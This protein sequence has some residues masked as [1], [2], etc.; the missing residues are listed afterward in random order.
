MATSSLPAV[1]VAL[2]STI[3]TATDADIQVAYGHPGKHLAAES[4]IVGDTD[5]ADQA[6]ASLGARTRTENYSIKVD[7]LI[8]KAYATQQE[9]TERAFD[10]FADIETA[11]RANVT[12]GVAG[13]RIEVQA[14]PRQLQEGVVDD[15]GLGY[16]AVLRTL[17][18]VTARI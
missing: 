7:I 1:K 4:V 17:A 16:G 10:V 11:L 18:R 9:A 8:L 2:V 5:D 3:D 14:V 15:N 13:K 6:W 12:L